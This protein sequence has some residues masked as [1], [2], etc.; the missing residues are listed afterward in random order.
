MS[1]RRTQLSK[2]L[3]EY[4]NDF[5]IELGQLVISFQELESCIR[6]LYFYINERSKIKKDSINNIKLINVCKLLDDLLVG[7]NMFNE[8]KEH[9]S[10][11]ENLKTINNFRNK[12]IHSVYLDFADRNKKLMFKFKNKTKDIKFELISEESLSFLVD[13]IESLIHKYEIF[14]NRIKEKI[15]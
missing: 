2:Y 13:E 9:L 11:F 7:N 5:L 1:S 4:N 12:I 8:R 10:L 14:Y 3:C 15:K 6:N